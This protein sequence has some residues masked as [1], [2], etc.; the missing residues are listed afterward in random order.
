MTP[1]TIFDI[2]SLTKG[3]ATATSMM[4]LLEDGR[5]RLND[6]VSTLRA[7]LEASERLLAEHRAR[8]NLAKPE[9]GTLAEQQASQINVQLV[10]V[11][12]QIAE[13]R[14]KYEQA[15]RVLDGGAAAREALGVGGDLREV[16]DAAHLELVPE[17][18]EFCADDIGDASSDTG[19][20]LVEDQRS[21]ST[22]SPA[23][24]EIYRRAPSSKSPPA[25]PAPRSPA[26]SAT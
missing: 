21:R 17:F 25:S 3:V 11:R 22:A 4:I 7:K 15:Q 14:A 23:R 8:H 13:S 20:Y 2:A 10:A 1:D 16:G 6:R 5:I 18:T 19:V 9:A 12:A 26:R 24:A